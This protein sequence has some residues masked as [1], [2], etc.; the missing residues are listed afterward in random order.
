MPRRVLSLVTTNVM[1]ARLLPGDYVA[2]HTNIWFTIY[3][4]TAWKAARS[5]TAT[6]RLD[7]PWLTA[8]ETRPA[9]AVGGR[10]VPAVVAGRG[11]AVV[12]EVVT[13]T[14]LA[15]LVVAGGAAVAVD[16]GALVGASVGAGLSDCVGAGVAVVGSGGAVDVQEAGRLQRESSTMR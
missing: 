7:T 12:A 1:R 14:V 3:T 6:S 2:L 5:A 16:V 9:V 10:I 15:G 8:P 13:V 4:K 11:V